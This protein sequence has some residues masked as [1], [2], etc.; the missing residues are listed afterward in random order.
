[1][2]RTNMSQFS[3]ADLLAES[4]DSDNEIIDS[5]Q[6]QSHFKPTLTVERFSN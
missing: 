4:E 5:G 6:T 3:L 1:M 2:R